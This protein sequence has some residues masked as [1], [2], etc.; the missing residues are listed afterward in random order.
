[1]NADVRDASVRDQAHVPEDPDRGGVRPPSLTRAKPPAGGVVGHP[2]GTCVSLTDSARLVQFV[3]WQMRTGDLPRDVADAAAR[4]AAVTPR[5]AHLTGQIPC[6]KAPLIIEGVPATD[7]PVDRHHAFPHHAGTVINE[8]LD[9]GFSYIL[10]Q[11][12]N[13]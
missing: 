6:T 5:P 9:K 12:L 11:D 13:G 8:L 7:S 1:M 2:S 10:V 4:L 3:V